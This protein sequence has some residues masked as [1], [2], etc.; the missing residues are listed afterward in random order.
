MDAPWTEYS[1][2]QRTIEWKVQKFRKE[3]Q[4]TKYLGVSLF[5]HTHI[6]ML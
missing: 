4:S 6:H 5:K 2:V 1:K 3:A